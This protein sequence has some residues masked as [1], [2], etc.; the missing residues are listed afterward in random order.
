VV[1]VGVDWLDE[2]IPTPEKKAL[3]GSKRK[4]WTSNALDEIDFI[5]LSQYLLHPYCIGPADKVLNE[6]PNIETLDEL[7]TFKNRFELKSNWSR[8]FFEIVDCEE[9]FLR[10]RWEALYLL[11][12]KVAHNSLINRTDYENIV[13]LASEIEKPLL[14]AIE[15]IQEIKV[16]EEELEQ[17]A[18]EADSTQTRAMEFTILVKDM[19]MMDTPSLS[20]RRSLWKT[21]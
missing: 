13:R 4:G 11:R 21:R 19:K 12:C 5:F 15:K 17:V 2:S 18:A 16:P 9:E 8:Y 20:E 1:N 3:D 14:L 6:L 7:A 10:K